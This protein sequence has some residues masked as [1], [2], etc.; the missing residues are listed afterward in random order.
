MGE[1]VRFYRLELSTALGTDVRESRI[2]NTMDTRHIQSDIDEHL[3]RLARKTATV[4][5]RCGLSWSYARRR[6]RRYQQMRHLQADECR[7]GRFVVRGHTDL[8]RL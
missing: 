8:R 7:D 1:L 2:G 3:Q 4:P 6:S 5:L